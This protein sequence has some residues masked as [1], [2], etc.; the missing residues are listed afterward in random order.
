[1]IPLS[2]DRPNLIVVT[3]LALILWMIPFTRPW[4]KLWDISPH[5]NAAF[6]LMIVQASYVHGWV[7]YLEAH[8]NSQDHVYCPEASVFYIFNLWLSFFEAIRDSHVSTMRILGCSH[9]RAH[10]I[11]TYLGDGTWIVFWQC[12]HAVT[13]IFEPMFKYISR[14]WKPNAWKEHDC[15]WWSNY[16]R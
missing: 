8:I 6:R 2:L 1:M 13:N 7:A 3:L 9:Q 11:N 5:L 14:V 4:H 12:S 10:E 15:N 16:I